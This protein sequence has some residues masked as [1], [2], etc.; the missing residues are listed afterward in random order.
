MQ[1]PLAGLRDLVKV[2]YCVVGTGPAGI[3]CALKLATASTRVL[4]LEAGDQH[5]S[6]ESQQLYEG[7]VVGDDYFPL[8]VMRLRFLGG[9]SNHW[10]GWC[11]PLDQI[12]LEGKG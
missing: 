3:T 8:E 6:A 12:D 9:T 5:I 11:R 10:S 7:E 1:L 2:D 4:L